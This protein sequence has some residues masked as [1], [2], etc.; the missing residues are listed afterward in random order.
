LGGSD[1]VISGDSSMKV[2]RRLNVVSGGSVV[3]SI[4]VI[5]SVLVLLDV[6]G[7]ADVVGEGGEGGNQYFTGSDS[8]SEGIGVDVDVVFANSSR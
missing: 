3:G 7:I 5:I 1:G 2:T 4:V 8:P 6:K